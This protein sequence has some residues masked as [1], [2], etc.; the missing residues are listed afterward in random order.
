MKRLN[1]TVKVLVLAIAGA[2]AAAGSASVFA[3]D[4]TFVINAREN[5][6]PTYNPI[7]GTKLNVANNLIFDRMVKEK[8]I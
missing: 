4:A 6:F 8:K 5:G 2:C 3:Q 1:H 7:K